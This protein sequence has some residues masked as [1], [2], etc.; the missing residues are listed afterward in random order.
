MRRALVQPAD[1]RGEARVG[2]PADQAL[3]RAGAGRAPQ[4]LD[5]QHLQQPRQH[6]LARGPLFARLVAHQLHQRGEAMLA[7]HMHEL[8]Q[9]R[10]QQRGIG[11][12]EAAVAAHEAHVDRPVR[13]A[14]AEFA[15]ADGHRRR[16]PQPR[17]RGLQ[18]GQRQAVGSGNQHEIARLQLDRLAAVRLDAATALEDGAIEGLAGV[19]AADPPRTG[20]DDELREPR[21]RLEQGDHLGQWI[22]HCRTLANEMWTLDCS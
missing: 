11:R 2:Q 3:R 16:R 22:D 18:A 15:V 21:G 1:G 19:R 6:D 17:R 8:R 10:H 13:P 20:S 14:D 4:R 5:E 7:A 12:T 9:Q